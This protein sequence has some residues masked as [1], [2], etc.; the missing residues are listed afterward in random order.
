[1]GTRAA[2]AFAV[3]LV[4][5][6]GVLRA[7]SPGIVLVVVATWPIGI[8]MGL[9]GALAPMAIKQHLADRPAEATGIYTT[10]MQIGSAVSSA[11]AIPIADALGGWRWALG[12]FGVVSIGLAGAWCLLTR[13]EPTHERPELRPARLPWGSGV[14][15]LLVAL[16]AL[17]ASGYYGL[18]AW[19]PDSYV[20][21]GWSAVRAGDLLAV[22][23]AAAILGSFVIPWVSDRH[24]GRR[25]WLLAMSGA[26]LGGMLMVVLVPAGAYAWA[27]LMG[28]ANGAL[29][30][31]VLTL[32]LDLERDPRH[33]GALVGM[34]LG[35]GY[36]LGALSPFVLGAV[37]DVTGTFTGSL[38]L[39]VAFSAAMLAA[40]A[41]LP[42][43][44]SSGVP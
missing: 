12:A 5:V 28:I 4:G 2:M 1:V 26:F 22:L 27:A 8:G 11:L 7:L 19:L 36:T 38:W 21:R 37:R 6:F 43:R 40:V 15:W 13:A 24:G 34:M 18:N 3:L 25:P 33:V 14:A 35:V 17:M 31:L 44:S 10:G 23:N 41:L 16:F 9:A 39:L 42:Q 32:P 20:E 30:P 29:F